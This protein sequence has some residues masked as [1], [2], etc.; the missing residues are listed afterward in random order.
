MLTADGR[1]QGAPVNHSEYS[2]GGPSG[3]VGNQAPP[4][5]RAEASSIPNS[6]CQGSL[7]SCSQLLLD[8]PLDLNTS[9]ISE[10]LACAK[11]E[12]ASKGSR[13]KR[14]RL[15]SPEGEDRG[16]EDSPVRTREPAEAATTWHQGRQEL[17]SSLARKRLSPASPS[18]AS[19]ASSVC[20]Q[21]SDE[22]GLGQGW[23][24]HRE[25]LT[26]RAEHRKPL[27]SRSSRPPISVFLNSPAQLSATP[28]RQRHD[29]SW[30]PASQSP[31][32]HAVTIQRRQDHLHKLP[33]RDPT[34]QIY[35]GPLLRQQE[36]KSSAGPSGGRKLPAQRLQRL[37]VSPSRPSGYPKYEGLKSGCE[38]HT[39]N[40]HTLHLGLQ[41]EPRI[42]ASTPGLASCGWSTHEARK[43][44]SSRQPDSWQQHGPHH[45]AQHAG[46]GAK[47]LQNRSPSHLAL[48]EL[49]AAPRSGLLQAPMNRR[50]EL[51]KGSPDRH[52]ALQE[53]RRFVHL[54]DN[55]VQLREGE[56]GSRRALGLQITELDFQKAKQTLVRIPL[57][58]RGPDLYHYPL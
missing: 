50:P 58:I 14:G 19:H 22:Q 55:T 57:Q 23:V 30:P 3:N 34:S 46:G 45:S 4:K 12:H 16:R 40:A 35:D 56:I 2:Q 29:S 7:Q 36:R 20:S 31:R 18:T 21:P 15:L 17:T 33:E 41:A 52:G 43:S 42:I 27:Q 32:R 10:A 51:G 28:A 1:P 25:L 39:L 26:S 5:Q 47:R 48:H 11:K 9:K 54:S 37:A 49:P 44:A 38:Y 6:P 53:S 24:M 8:P 13:A